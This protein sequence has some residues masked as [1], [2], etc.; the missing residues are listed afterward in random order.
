MTYEQTSTKASRCF[1][2]TAWGKRSSAE[3]VKDSRTVEVER[4]KSFCS[5]YPVKRL[6]I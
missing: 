2:S 6:T 5:T 4:C 1:F 3:N